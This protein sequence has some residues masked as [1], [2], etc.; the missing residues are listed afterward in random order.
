MK[1]LLAVI[2]IVA[3]TA[4][5]VAPQSSTSAIDIGTGSGG[6]AC[7]SNGADN[8]VCA[9]KAET[10]DSFAKTIINSLI[11]ILGII[12]VLVIVIAGFMYVVSAGASSTVTK[13][14]D[15]ILYAVIGLVVAILAFSIVNFV[16]GRF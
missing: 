11:Y 3:A 10:V 4:L 7:T 14:K 8:A 6:T 5:L 2:S 15:A 13:A 16:L 12:S 9:G 1:L